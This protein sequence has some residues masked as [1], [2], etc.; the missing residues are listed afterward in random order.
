MI[1]DQTIQP[2]ELVARVKTLLRRNER[3]VD[4]ATALMQVGIYRLILPL[5]SSN[6]ESWFCALRV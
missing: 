2:R 3:K 5:R 4:P 1:T 6:W